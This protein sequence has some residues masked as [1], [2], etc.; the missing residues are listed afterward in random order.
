MS[1][2]YGPSPDA[3]N[4]GVPPT[5]PNARAGLLTPPGIDL[6]ERANASSLAGRD[7]VMD[8]LSKRFCAEN[9][10]DKFP[11]AIEN[12]IQRSP[13]VGL[14][15]EFNNSQ[16]FLFGQQIDDVESNT[17]VGHIKLNKVGQFSKLSESVV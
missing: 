2:R 5:A 17:G 14:V 3:M 1:V 12:S 11:G 13:D 6:T 16:A 9:Q 10:R 15:F 4:G 8:F 7:T